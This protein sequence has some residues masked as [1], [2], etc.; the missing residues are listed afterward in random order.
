MSEHWVGEISVWVGVAGRTMTR[1][2][3]GRRKT[4][5]I[6]PSQ[7]PSATAIGKHYPPRALASA[8][9]VVDCQSVKDALQVGDLL[10]INCERRNHHMEKEP[11]GST[12]KK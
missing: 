6:G 12:S 4:D 8:H 1:S 11:R 10:E 2:V 5:G 7:V 3:R 9:L